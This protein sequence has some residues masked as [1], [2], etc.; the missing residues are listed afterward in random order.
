MKKDK[1]LAQSRAKAIFDFLVAQGIAQSQLQ[2]VGIG[3]DRP[4]GSANPSDPINE[5]IDFIKAQQ[6]AT[7]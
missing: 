4:L 7:P 1:A 5:R 6:G 3:S 2:A